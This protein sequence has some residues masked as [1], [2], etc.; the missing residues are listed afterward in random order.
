MHEG[1]LESL[2]LRELMW[3]LFLNGIWLVAELYSMYTYMILSY[4]NPK[5]VPANE[6]IPVNPIRYPGK[7]DSKTVIVGNECEEQLISSNACYIL[8]IRFIWVFYSVRC[9]SRTSYRRIPFSLCHTKR[10]ISPPP[11]PTRAF[12]AIMY[13]SGK[14]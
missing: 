9:Y 12:H 14:V 6:N 5:S 13:P 3:L 11:L 4:R 10:V 7:Y 2:L 8:L 1:G